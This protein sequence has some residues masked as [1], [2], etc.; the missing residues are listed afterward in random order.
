MTIWF[1]NQFI[2]GTFR[3]LGIKI[4]VYKVNV[5]RRINGMI[6]C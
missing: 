4:T 6:M 1:I 2:K 5:L 3:I